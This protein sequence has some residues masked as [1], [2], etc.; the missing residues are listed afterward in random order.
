MTEND[1]DI[2]G[3]FVLGTLDAAERDAALARRA[4]DPAFDTAVAAWEDRL[5]PLTEGIAE[6]VPPAHLWPAILARIAGRAPTSVRSDVMPY[7][8]NVVLFRQVVRWRRIAG[9]MTALA[10]ALALWAAIGPLVQGGSNRPQ[11][12]A[13]LMKGGDAPAY[14]MRLSLRDDEIAV[15][16]VSAK[17]PEGKSYELWVIDPALGAP[18]SLGTLGDASGLH[19][20]PSDVSSDVARRGTYAVTVEPLGGSPT[21]KPSGAPVFVGQ[22]IDAP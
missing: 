10:A 15:R 22:V 17:T 21:G 1:D 14:L 18:R 11:M 19:K 6:A 8:T 20:I 3:E 2:A 4:I 7:D 13:V 5:A 9:S 16:P 12:I